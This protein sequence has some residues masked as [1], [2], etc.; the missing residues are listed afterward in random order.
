[1]AKDYGE[2]ELF[3]EGGSPFARRV[4]I[5]LELKVVQYT[6]FEEESTHY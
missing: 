2:V 5:D 6:Y 3:G 4:Q 1:M